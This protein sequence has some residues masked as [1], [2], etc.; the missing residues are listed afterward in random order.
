M[1]G[2]QNR[3]KNKGGAG[4]GLTMG[5][6]PSVE[7]A[8]LESWPLRDAGERLGRSR[9][10]LGTWTKQ[11]RGQHAR[12]LLQEIERGR[13]NKRRSSARQKTEQRRPRTSGGGRRAWIRRGTWH[14]A[15]TQGL[16]QAAGGST[17]RQRSTFSWI[18]ES[19]GLGDVDAGVGVLGHGVWKEELVL[20]VSAR[21]ARSRGDR[22][23]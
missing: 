12:R 1:L 4:S 21:E 5:Q 17:T 8:S 23:C 18:A 6:G 3:E 11:G 14:T 10:G 2:Q 15:G 7:E 19:R 13:E 22:W 9:G 16:Q 20:L